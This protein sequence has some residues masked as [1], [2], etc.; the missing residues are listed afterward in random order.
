MSRPSAGEAHQRHAHGDHQNSKDSLQ[1]VP[2]DE[3]AHSGH[4]LLDELDYLE[5]I[6]QVVPSGENHQ[7]EYQNQTESETVFLGPRP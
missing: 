2:Q 7:E 4:E 6:H 1:E 3:Y 5:M